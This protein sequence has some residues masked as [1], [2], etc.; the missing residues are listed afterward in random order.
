MGLYGEHPQADRVQASLAALG[1][2][3]EIK[4]SL[5]PG[6]VATVK[7]PKGVVELR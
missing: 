6:L 4:Q 3:L 1:V 2:E 5:Q 7:T